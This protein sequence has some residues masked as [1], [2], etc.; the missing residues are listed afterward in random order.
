VR[1]YALGK[2]SGKANIRKNL[3]TLG[4]KLEAADLAKVT[5]KIIELGDK[6]QVVTQEELP[7]I[8][9]DIL[10]NDVKEQRIKLI[11]YSFSLAKGLRPMATVKME[12]DGETY[13][14][15]AAGD[16]QYNAFTKVLWK[17][18]TNLNKPKP[19][20]L[21]YVVT[22]PPGGRTDALV[23]T[24]ITWRF[25]EKIFKTHGLDPDQTEAAVKATVKML[26][27]IEE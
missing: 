20:L 6:K 1:E 13:E 22:I 18:Y 23:H 4:I 10:K 11:N 2:L 27:L 12:I 16:G 8:I 7:Y 15:T 14:A 24:T 21:D 19:E 9:S 25:G 5:Q 3:E 17:I 26:N